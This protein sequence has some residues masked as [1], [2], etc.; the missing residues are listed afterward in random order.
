MGVVDAV[1]CGA[2]CCA[3]AAPAIA[4]TIRTVDRNRVYFIL[5][6]SLRNLHTAVL[7]GQLSIFAAN[8]QAHDVAAGLHIEAAL[9]RYA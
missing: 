4:S 6:T 2:P 1:F 3:A 9:Q 8:Y 5:P 7:R